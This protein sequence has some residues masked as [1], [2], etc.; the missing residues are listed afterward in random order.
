MYVGGSG[1]VSRK[2]IF[3]ECLPPPPTVSDPSQYQFPILV[4]HMFLLMLQK[5]RYFYSMS[6]LFLNFPSSVFVSGGGAAIVAWAIVA[7]TYV[8]HGHFSSS[9]SS[10]KQTSKGWSKSD[11]KLPSLSEWT[12]IE[13]FWIMTELGKCFQV[14]T[15]VATNH[16]IPIPPI[17]I[18]HSADT[19]SA[20]T[21]MYFFFAK[22]SQAL[23]PAQLAD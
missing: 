14:C 5:E 23:T 17:F 4:A 8:S 9:S 21:I 20:F 22:L 2:V 12:K 6:Y 3:Q 1:W 13:I 7:L 15:F 19:Q 16:C 18:I 10:Q 11:M